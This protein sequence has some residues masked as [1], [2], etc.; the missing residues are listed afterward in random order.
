MQ[1]GLR[2]DIG[3]VLLLLTLALLWY[4]PSLHRYRWFCIGIIFESSSFWG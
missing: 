3:S 2:S 4:V 1:A